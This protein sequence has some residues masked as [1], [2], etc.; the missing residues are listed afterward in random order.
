VASALAMSGAFAVGPHEA[1]ASRWRLAGLAEGVASV[2]GAD[3]E[4]AAPRVY[5]CTPRSIRGVM[6]A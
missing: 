2:V 4:G 5:G 3:E 1:Y 6:R